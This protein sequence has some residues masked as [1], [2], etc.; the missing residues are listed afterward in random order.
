RP[1]AI[2]PE[3]ARIGA[4]VFGLAV[5]LALQPQDLPS[6]VAE[7]VAHLASE[8]P[9]IRTAATDALV[10]LGRRAIPALEATKSDD[11]QVRSRVARAISR[12][13]TTHPFYLVR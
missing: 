13:Q 1:S 2:R 12:I 4:M 5:A 9:R 7:Q 6:R 3:D 10:R 11:P 8:D